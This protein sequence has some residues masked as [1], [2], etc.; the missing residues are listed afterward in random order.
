MY[1]D[2]EVAGVVY[3]QFVK[4]DPQPPKILA[5]G[6]ISTAKNLMTSGPLYERA[7]TRMYGKKGLA[8]KPNRDFLTNLMTKEDENNDKYIQRTYIERNRSMVEA[9]AQKILLELEDMLNPDLP[10]Y[11]NPTRDCSRMCSFLAPCVSFD[12][13]SDWE[14][15]LEDRFSERD[16]LSDYW[17]RRIPDPKTLAEMREA[18]VVPDLFDAQIRLEKMSPAEQDAIE[19]GDAALEF[20]FNME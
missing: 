3:H 1:P 11:P 8:P 18:R 10:L 5:N 4:N 13:G 15:Y 20:T 7:L 14:H 19:R 12:D 16:G 9:E 2:R 6:N 17:R